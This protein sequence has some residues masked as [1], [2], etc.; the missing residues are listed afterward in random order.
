MGPYCNKEG[1]NTSVASSQ[2]DAYVNHVVKAETELA[3]GPNHGRKLSWE[4][5]KLHLSYFIHPSPDTHFE[6]TLF[7]FS[8]SQQTNFI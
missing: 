5:T 2:R 6:I 8:E 3:L 1:V 4:A 7:I